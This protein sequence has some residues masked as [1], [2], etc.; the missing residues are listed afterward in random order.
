MPVVY[1]TGGIWYQ[2][3]MVQV[4]YSASWYMVFAV[5]VS[6]SLCCWVYVVL[7]VFAAG[8]MLPVVYFSGQLLLCCQSYISLAA[9]SAG[10]VPMLG[11]SVPYHDVAPWL[12]VALVE[13]LG[14]A[15][16]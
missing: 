2:K 5:C 12:H 15:H 1:Y 7:M 8:S 14:R 13:N 9:Y 11:T 10:W 16:L 6:G 4:V 3:Y